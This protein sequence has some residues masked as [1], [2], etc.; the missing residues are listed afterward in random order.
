MIGVDDEIEYWRGD[1]KEAMGYLVTERP[2][3]PGKYI[4]TF[5]TGFWEYDAATGTTR[6]LGIETNGYLSDA[7]WEERD[8]GWFMVAAT[9]E[10]TIQVNFATGERETH[11]IDYRNPIIVQKLFNGPD[12]MYASGYM[13]GLAPFDAESGEI[14][15]TY[16]EGQFESSAVR[17]DKML[18]GAYGYALLKEFDPATG[19]FTEIYSL[20]EEGQDRPFGLDY[21]P[22]TDRSFM[23]SVPYYGSHQG[24]LTMHDFATG[25]TKV[26]KEEIVPNQAFIDVLHHDGLVYLG[27]T[28]DGGLGGEP[29]GETDAHFVVWDPKTEQVVH[30]IIPVAGDEGVTGLM[31]GPDG[32]IWG[33]SEDTVFKYD[34]AQGKIVYSEKLLGNRYGSSTVWAWA[35]L[36]IGSDGNVYGTNRSSLFKIDA[37][38]MQYSRIVDGTGNYLVAD[39]N[40][41]VFFSSSAYLFKYDVPDAP[42][43]ECTTVLEGTVRGGLAVEGDEVICGAGVTIEGAVG[44]RAGGALRLEDSTLRGGLTADGATEVRIRTSQLFGAVSITG[45][46]DAFVFAG[47]ELRGSMTC[48]D[49]DAPI[50]DEGNVSIVSGAISGCGEL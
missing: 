2:D 45:V 48:A 40:G 44:V 50:D 11:T 26:F 9:Q 17:G 1:G 34:P 36:A 8:S 37:D 14:A 12:T 30:D 31:V 47:N 43:S 18:L 25:E 10:G 4:Y 27:T 23:A 15:E 22:V 6:D 5:Q 13:V 3:A 20:R 49:N 39:D 29:S 28:I 46:T 16:Q 19:A 41:D 42:A 32:L 38:T 35:Y 21:D 33:V 24:A 7:F